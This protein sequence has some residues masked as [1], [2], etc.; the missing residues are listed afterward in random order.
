MKTFVV[1]LS[2]LCSLSAFA[3]QFYLT[4][5]LKCDQIKSELVVS[6]GGSWNDAPES[7]VGG[8]TSDVVDPRKLVAFSQDATGKYSIATKSENRVCLISGKEYAIE[9]SPLMA[10]RFHP[11]GFC[12][13]RI[14]A[15]VAIRLRGV[16]VA[17]AGVDAC[18]EIGNVTAT[19]SV[20]PNRKPRYKTVD[21][22][23]FYGT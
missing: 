6:F 17:E 16:V 8:L 2:A 10:P 3:D 11:E 9:V 18:T 5:N 22:K 19:V 23:Q 4:A 13:T 1:F 14:G 12:A 21:A 7:T 20:K 15:K